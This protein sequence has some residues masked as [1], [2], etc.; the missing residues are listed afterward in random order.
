MAV[1][2]ERIRTTTELDEARSRL[3]GG[4]A[5]TLKVQ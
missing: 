1:D 3:R 2:G 5:P 4:D